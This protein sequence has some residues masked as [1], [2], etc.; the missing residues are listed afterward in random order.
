MISS[1]ANILR[2]KFNALRV[3]FFKTG[4]TCLQKVKDLDG[5]GREEGV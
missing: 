1:T 4:C 2:I 5:D 3:R